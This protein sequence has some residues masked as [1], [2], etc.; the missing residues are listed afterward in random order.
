MEQEKQCGVHQPGAIAVFP[1]FPLLGPRTQ[2]NKNLP[3]PQKLRCEGPDH[4]QLAFG[5]LSTQL[6]HFSTLSRGAGKDYL[7]DPSGSQMKS[8]CILAGGFWWLRRGTEQPAGDCGCRFLINERDRGPW[9]K[10]TSFLENKNQRYLKSHELTLTEEA[11]MKQKE[12]Q[13]QTDTPGLESQLLALVFHFSELQLPHLWTRSKNLH[14][15]VL[16]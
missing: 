14:F 4:M 8:H 9:F 11:L 2:G 1:I 15:P 5:G 6:F 13:L 3:V 10:S 16:Q 7:W 12:R